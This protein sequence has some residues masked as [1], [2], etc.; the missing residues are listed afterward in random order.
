M[1]PGGAGAPRRAH[2]RPEK[3]TNPNSTAKSLRSV[4]RPTTQPTRVCSGSKDS[5][6]Y[7]ATVFDAAALARGHRVGF[8][9]SGLPNNKSHGDHPEVTRTS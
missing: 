9:G 5:I 6:R 2:R 8:G 3:E 1:G 7:S 4:V